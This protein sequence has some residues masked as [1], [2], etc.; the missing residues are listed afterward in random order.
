MLAS[1]VI[2]RYEAYCPQELSMEGDVC[3]LQ[4]GTLQKDIQ[5]VMVALDIRE[6]T[7]A[8]AIAH[9]VDLIIVKHAPIFRPI[10]DLVADRAQN[11]IYIDL[12][13]HDIA[14]YV[15]IPILTLSQ[16]VS[17]I[18]SASSWTLKIQSPSV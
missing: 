17:T 3:G 4:V 2:K 6:Q 7:V 10:K 14:V 18:G 8:E 16:M 5:K 15:S 12:I 9:G 13:K 1:E 11:Q